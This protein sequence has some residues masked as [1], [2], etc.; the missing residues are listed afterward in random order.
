M[1]HNRGVTLPRGGLGLDGPAVSGS[2]G[3][4]HRSRLCLRA[5]TAR[6]AGRAAAR[7]IGARAT[8][9]PAAAAPTLCELPVPSM[10]SP[11]G[12]EAIACS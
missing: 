6:S 5:V 2:Y 4:Q 3:V 9:A 7:T 8:S 12:G 1:Q 10:T 11:M